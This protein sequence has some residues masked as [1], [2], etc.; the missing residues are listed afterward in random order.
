MCAKA[1][2]AVREGTV[3][4]RHIGTAE[5]EAERPGLLVLHQRSSR[6]ALCYLLRITPWPQTCGA[7]YRYPHPFVTVALLAENFPQPFVNFPHPLVNFPQPFV[8]C[9]I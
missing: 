9:F 1:G 2:K 5:K 3:L 4:M 8:A 7:D 6:D